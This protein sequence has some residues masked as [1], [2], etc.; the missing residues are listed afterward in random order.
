[1][2]VGLLHVSGMG[3]GYRWDIIP[4]YRSTTVKL[5][6]EESI[7]KHHSVW[8]M[9]VSKSLYKRANIVTKYQII[10]L[11]EKFFE[12]FWQL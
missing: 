5:T 10:F 3:Y 2:F 9:L 4:L 7:N 11:R 1:M 6:F 8:V 12:F